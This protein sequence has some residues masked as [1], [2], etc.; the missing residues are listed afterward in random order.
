MYS[1]LTHV[2]TGATDVVEQND[3]NLQSTLRWQLLS[4]ALSACMFD[5]SHFDEAGGAPLGRPKNPLTPLA[6]PSSLD[7]DRVARAKKVMGSISNATRYGCDI[8]GGG[9][10]CPSKANTNRQLG[11]MLSLPSL[12]APVTNFLNN[13]KDG[14]TRMLSY[15]QA[16]VPP[17]GRGD[18][19]NKIQF[20]RPTPSSPVGMN[21]QGDN[22]GSD[23]TYRLSIG[24]EEFGAPGVPV[25]I[26]NPLSCDKDGPYEKCWGNPKANDDR[27]GPESRMKTSIWALND[28][29]GEYKWQGQNG[30]HWRLQTVR[31]SV[32]NAH[33]DV[34]INLDRFCLLEIL[35]KCIAPKIDKFVGNVQPIGE[36]WHPW[37]GITPFS[38]FEPGQYASDCATSAVRRTG[39]PSASAAALNAQEFNQPSTWSMLRK[40]KDELRNP[41]GDPTA[42]RIDPALINSDGVLAPGIGDSITE[43]DMNNDEQPFGV[44][45]GMTVFARGQTYYHRPGVW[46]EQPN[47]FNPY[48]RP[49]LASVFQGYGQLPLLKNAIDRLP[50]PLNRFPQKIITH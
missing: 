13:I 48:W 17:R 3:P 38:H 25:S 6:R 36:S 32:M 33:W 45:D 14:Q 46:S 16:V 1:M 30:I 27:D 22:L 28:D 11:D 42:S 37:K 20:N 18:W 7:N 31:R 43:L 19:K 41:V 44:G 8:E 47:F 4:G 23:D 10:F 9:G 15:K 21:A 29:R 39:T 34:R 2:L 5:R 49:R 26:K 40:T 12:L 35:G 50:P 24:P